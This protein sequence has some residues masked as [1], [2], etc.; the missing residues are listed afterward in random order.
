MYA[1]AGTAGQRA[2]RCREG[3][4]GGIPLRWRAGGDLSCA[5]SIATGEPV[6]RSK[7]AARVRM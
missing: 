1:R 2:E 5:S 6:S 4:G 3:A 7:V